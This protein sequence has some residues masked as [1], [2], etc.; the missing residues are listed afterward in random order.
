MENPPASDTTI[1]QRQVAKLPLLW[2]LKT[3]RC[4]IYAIVV[5]ANAFDTGVEGFNSF[6]EMTPMQIGKLI[7]HIG[8]AVLTVWVAF[9]DQSMTEAER[10]KKQKQDLT[11]SN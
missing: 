10:A 7:E 2:K 1:W 6:T 4:S 5:G 8:V 3:I 11:G 9:L